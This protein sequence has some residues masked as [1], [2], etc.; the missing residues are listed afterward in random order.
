MCWLF[1]GFAFGF[2]IYLFFSLE[3]GAVVL[4]L[5]MFLIAIPIYVATISSS[6]DE[7]DNK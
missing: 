5:Y 1:G 2:F 7:D 3:W 4:A 6:P